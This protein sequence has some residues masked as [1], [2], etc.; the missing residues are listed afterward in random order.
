MFFYSRLLLWKTGAGRR[1][2]TGVRATGGINNSTPLMSCFFCVRN[3]LTFSVRIK[4]IIT[5]LDRASFSVP[6]LF[7]LAL[8]RSLSV[9]MLTTNKKL[10]NRANRQDQV[11]WP[12]LTSE[13]YMNSHP[14]RRGNSIA[15]VVTFFLQP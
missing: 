15:Q 14:L 13:L 12:K 6:S 11:L 5:F 8:S 4:K 2:P 3:K 7:S 1:V 10:I 9:V